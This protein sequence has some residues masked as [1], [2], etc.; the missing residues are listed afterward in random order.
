MWAETAFASG[1]FVRV[2]GIELGSSILQ[3]SSSKPD[4]PVADLLE[5]NLSMNRSGSVTPKLSAR[6]ELSRL[7]NFCE[8][9]RLTC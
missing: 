5:V 1:C 7:C 9:R 4:L 3:T 2:A 6:L 8:K